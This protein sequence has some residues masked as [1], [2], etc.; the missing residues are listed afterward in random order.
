MGRIDNQVKIRGFRI[1]LGEIENILSEHQAVQETVVMAHI[2]K[3]SNNKSLVAYVVQNLHY[4]SGEE[5]KELQGEQTEQWEM[6]F[7]NFYAQSPRTSDPT[8]NIIGWNSSYTGEPIPEGEMQYWLKTT[9]ER[10]LDLKPQ[11]ALEI[12]CGTGMILNRIAPKCKYYYGTD[13]SNKALNYIQK[14]IIERGKLSANVKLLHQSADNFQDLHD[15]EFDSIIMNS[16]IQYFPSIEYLVRVLEE[17]VKLIDSKGSIFLGDIRSLPLVEAFHTKVEMHHSKT[18]VTIEQFKKNIENRIKQD[19]ELV[20]DPEFFYALQRHMPEINEVV[21]LPKMGEFANE[22]TSFRYDVVLKIGTEPVLKTNYPS[23]DWNKDNLSLPLIRKQLEN[24]DTRILE[25]NNIKDARVNKDILLIDLLKNNLE[26]KTVADLRTL[27]EKENEDIGLNPEDFWRVAAEL[28]YDVEIKLS[29][30]V[31]S[32]CFNIIFKRQGLIEPLNQNQIRT[33]NIKR[34]VKSWKIYSNNP[35]QKKFVN[36]VVPEIKSYLKSKLPDYM[37]PSYFVLMDRFSLTPNGKV[38]RSKL[39]IPS[40]ERIDSESADYCMPRNPIEE[41]VAGIWTELLNVNKIGIYE[42]FFDLGGHSLLATQIVSRLRNILQIEVTVRSIFDAPSIAGLSEKIYAL[43]GVEYK[44]QI[45][46]TTINETEIKRPLSFAQQRLLFL[47]EFTSG[48]S[49]YSIPVALRLKGPLNVKVLQQALNEITRRHQALRT[50]FD[51]IKG[52]Q[53]QII[54]P[55]QGF[56]LSIKDFTEYPKEQRD[57]LVKQFIKSEVIRPFDLVQGPLFR[58]YLIYVDKTEYVLLL[59]MHHIISDGWSM[60]VLAKELFTLYEAFSIGDESPLPDLPI[61]YVDYAVWQREWLKE[62]V[63]EH[64]LAYWKKQLRGELPV[65]D[66]STNL[67]RPTTATFRGKVEKFI[68]S[69]KLTED[70]KKLSRQEGTTLFMTLLAAF[71]VLIYRY[72]S[73]E[74]IL[75]GAPIANRNW[76]EIEKLIGFFVNT[77]TLRTKLSDDL[78]FIELM[79]RVREVSLDAYANQDVPFEKVVEELQPERNINQSPLFQVMFQLTPEYNFKLSNLTV[80]SLEVHTETAKFDLYLPMTEEGNQLVGRLEYNSD[81][82]SLIRIKQIIKHFEIL[83][84]GIVCNPSQAIKDIPLLSEHENDTL[85]NWNNTLTP[86]P[87]EKCFHELF[88]EQ[89]EKTPDAIAVSFEE[90]KLTYRELNNRANQLAHYLKKQGIGPEVLVGICLERS[91][92]MIVSIMGIWKAGAAYVPLDPSYPES[93]LRYILEDTGIQVLVTNESLEDWIPKEIKIV[94]LDRDQA[95]ISQE[96]ILSPKCEVTGEN[97]AYV[98]YTSGSTGNP[99]GVLIQHHSVL[100]LSHGLQKE[101]FEHEIPSNMHVGLNASIAFDASIQQLQMLLY[102]SSLYI[103]PNE[104][105]SNPEQFVAYIREN[106]LEI[107]DI[108][109]SLLQ[110]L[111]DVGLLE[112]CDGAHV[113][114]KILVGGEAIMPSLWEQ[115]VETDKIEFYNVYGPTECTVDAT[116]YHIKKD[117]KRI[118]IG[119]SLPNVQTYV[120][121]KNGLQVPVG[122]KGEIYIGGEGLAR[123]YLNQPELTAE[124]FIIDSFS[125]RQGARLYKTGDLGR[126]LGDGNI[127]FLG[128]MDDQVKVRGYRIELGEIE[129]LLS[130]HPVVD[131]TAVLI[132]GDKT[133]DKR[134]VAYMTF[135]ENQMSSSNELREYLRGYLPEY[136]IPSVFKKLDTMPLTI[137]GKIDR[138]R[139]PKVRVERPD[140][141][142]TYVKPSNKIEEKIASAWSEVLEIEKIGVYDNFFVLGG[143]SLL[144][145]QVTSRLRN[146]LQVEIQLMDFFK[147]PTIFEM[148]EKIKKINNKI[149][150]NNIKPISRETYLQKRPN[151]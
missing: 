102:G 68:L 56:N 44:N 93:R 113:P 134:L 37:I 33:N 70:L 148:S 112:T 64:Q 135:K 92:E 82:F 4:E 59:N 88:E 22:L 84:E 130:Q 2:D 58:T 5:G 87:K 52:E 40:R 96:S 67:T 14:Q 26:I 39:P 137:N 129:T 116:C 99:K 117:S 122:V 118:T 3:E 108:T 69:E 42:N 132:Q 143:H 1:E 41:L 53:V 105:R 90:E 48:K 30:P 12:G 110:L 18:N 13:I 7:D 149:I 98:I 77:L 109:P 140:L 94:C 61:Q 124:K 36:T 106:K 104:V 62:E 151:I 8:F 139:L 27:L 74:D 83:L 17:S 63:L 10:I 32:G 38:D 11:V 101:V 75:I 85:L 80:D 57:L 73:E 120:L 126:Y 81:V 123:G 107:F 128:R 50:V 91:V 78:T 46:Q 141:E 31:I 45:P 125:G 35:L 89:V 16:V 19:N 145:M 51:N 79:K 111:I 28:S 71:K 86:Y 147:A 54:K 29:E 15:G 119:R 103:I 97:L 49:L 76:G 72:T 6:I 136:M 43:M 114:S 9:V 142:A 150:K 121:D 138:K 60:G 25:V 66:L 65:L 20:I 21:I 115:L 100:N 144:A 133:K 131:S 47:E 55:H 146:T 95:M 127:E 34:E 24:E 23:L